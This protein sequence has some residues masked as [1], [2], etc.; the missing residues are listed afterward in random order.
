MEIE[1]I[2]LYV[3]LAVLGG[4]ITV[5]CESFLDRSKDVE[6]ATLVKVVSALGLVLTIFSIIQIIQIVR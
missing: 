6:L 4:A 1:E 3:I 2:F 5:G